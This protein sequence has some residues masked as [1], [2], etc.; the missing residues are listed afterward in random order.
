LRQGTGNR[1]QATDKR[2]GYFNTFESLRE[3]LLACLFA[4][5]C[6]YHPMYG[7]AFCVNIVAYFNLHC[8][9]SREKL[10]RVR[11]SVEEWLKLEEY[12]ASKRYTLSE[13]VR[14]FIKNL[15]M[16]KKQT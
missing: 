4:I 15:P 2:Y 9:M 5:S 1:Q 16:P 10:L 11:L 8:Q 14:D 12:A 13:A 7:R 6:A 3:K